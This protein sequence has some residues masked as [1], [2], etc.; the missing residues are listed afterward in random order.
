MQ[1]KRGVFWVITLLIPIAV[2]F[3]VGEFGVR[4]LLAWQDANSYIT[5]GLY[6]TDH[7]LGWTLEP[8]KTIRHKSVD[9]DIHYQTDDSGRRRTLF[10]AS[11]GKRIAIY[12][13]SFAFGIGLEDSDTVATCLNRLL[14]PVKA[15]N[16]AVPGFSPDQYYMQFRRDL[17][18]SETRP[19]IAVFLILLANDLMDINFHHLTGS[20]SQQRAKPLFVRTDNGFVLEP[21]VLPTNPQTTTAVT[22][23]AATPNN[24]TIGYRSTVLTELLRKSQLLRWLYVNMGSRSAFISNLASKVNAQDVD[25]AMIEE[26]I[27]RFEWVVTR[28]KDTRVPVV[29]VVIPSENLLLGKNLGGREDNTYRAVKTSLGNIGVHYVDLLERF[30]RERGLYFPNEGHWNSRGAAFTAMT[31]ARELISQ[32]YIRGEIYENSRHCATEAQPR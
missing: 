28:I 7:Q 3:A 8:N 5:P 24:E 6:R 19:D 30:P 10:T 32:R 1:I 31:L 14:E 17:D 9:F 15:V 18:S 23:P 13:D 25:A 16:A 11:S 4:T 27:K 2:I 22:T 20:G 12:G 21:A 29:Y 26:G